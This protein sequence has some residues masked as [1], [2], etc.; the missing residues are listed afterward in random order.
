MPSQSLY[1]YLA[2]CTGVPGLGN[3]CIT[4]TNAV[5]VK[6]SGTS[7]AHIEQNAQAN[8]ANDACLSVDTGGTVIVGYQLVNCSG[9]DT[10]IGSMTAVTNSHAGDGSAYAIKICATALAPQTL[11]FDVS[12]ATIGFGTLSSGAARYATGNLAGSA[13]EVEAHTLS[14]SSTASSGY[15]L[16]VRGDTLANGAKTIT[17]I[18][19]TNTGSSPGSEQFGLR[20]VPSGGSGTVTAPYAA[21]GFAFNAT[22]TSTVQI[23]STTAPDTTPTVFSARY[24]A[25]ITAVTEA[26]DYSTTLT[27]IATGTF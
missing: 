14:V 5:V 10:T 6:L 23:A 25:N 18:G 3:S 19:G 15:T 2:C 9:F 24:L 13:S 7:N 1:T 16:T 22:G 8:Y 11:T 20:F 17:A 12:D 26:S 4:G 27:Y 21:A